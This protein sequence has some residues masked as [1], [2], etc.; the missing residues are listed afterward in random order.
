MFCGGISCGEKNHYGQHL[1]VSPLLNK[2]PPLPTRLRTPGDGLDRYDADCSGKSS[3]KFPQLS[4]VREKDL[5]GFLGPC[6]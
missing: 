5:K 6:T 3:L 1:S 4:S 2:T